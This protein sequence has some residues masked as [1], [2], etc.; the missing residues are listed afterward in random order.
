MTEIPT[1]TPAEMQKKFART[2]RGL[3]MMQAAPGCELLDS[4]EFELIR[5]LLDRIELN[6][7]KRYREYQIAH[8]SQQLAH[9]S[10]TEGELVRDAL[11]NGSPDWPDEMSHRQF[12]RKL[13]QEGGSK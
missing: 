6:V 8:G 9:E 4:S 2:M 13:R 3:T 7:R 5:Q 1:I 12:A 11:N 10:K